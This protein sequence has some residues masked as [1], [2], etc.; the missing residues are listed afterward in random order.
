[1]VLMLTLTLLFVG[2]LGFVKFKQIQTAIAQG[3]AFQ[4]PPEA[5]TTMVAAQEQVL[6]SGD[7]LWPWDDL[8]PDDVV[9][10]PTTMAELNAAKNT[11]TFWEA[12]THSILDVDRVIGGDDDQIGAI[13]ALDGD[14]LN[15][16]FGTI[17]PSLEDFQRIPMW[18]QE[19]NE[20]GTLSDLT[21][22]RWTGR[23]LVLYRDNKP[24]EVVFWGFSGD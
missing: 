22:T 1:M 2:G 11:E 8:D 7:F 10:R 18:T 16:W 5:V 13:R 4:P 9:P 12:G 15:K 23:S 21:E 6:A 19:M 14:E 20:T 3:A 17:E 24:D